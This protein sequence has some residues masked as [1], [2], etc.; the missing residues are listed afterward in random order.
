MGK[1]Y[2]E[3]MREF[4]LRGLCNFCNVCIKNDCEG[5]PVADLCHNC[6]GDFSKLSIIE[7]KN[8]VKLIKDYLGSNTEIIYDNINH[9]TYYANGNIEVWD[10][11]KDKN[12]NYDRGCAIK[13]ICRAGLKDK[14][15]EVE[16]LKKAIN[17]LN[18]EIKHLEKEKEN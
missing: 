17:Y 3:D 13:Y 15:K 18:H 10:F 2:D 7:I 4:Y 8:A 12:L 9:P 11:I 5:C 14:N 6:A 1:S 16:D